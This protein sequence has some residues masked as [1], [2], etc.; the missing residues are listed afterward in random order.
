MDPDGSITTD[1]GTLI[2]CVRE[3]ESRRLPKEPA[4]PCARQPHTHRALG[5]RTLDPTP[6]IANATGKGPH[7]LTTTNPFTCQ[8]ALAAESYGEPGIITALA[9]ES[10]RYLQPSKE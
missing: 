9:D 1:Y 6:F 5:R 4:A 8:T 2:L 10:S 3:N 7:I